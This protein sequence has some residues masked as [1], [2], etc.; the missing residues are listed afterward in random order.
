M[1]APPA[2]P[3]R[4]LWDDYTQFHRLAVATQDVDPVYPVLRHV[5]GA[6]GL[7]GLAVDAV[8]LHVAYY[9][10]G[11]ALT[12]LELRAAGTRYADLPTGLPTATERRAHRDQRQFA[13]HLRHLDDLVAL[14]GSLVRYLDAAT[15]P[16]D[17]AA[18]WTAL[19]ARVEAVHGN[20]RWAS[21]KTAEML[22]KVAGWPLAAPDMGMAG[23]SGPAHGL[24]RLGLAAPEAPPAALEDAGRLVVKSLAAAG[25]AGADLATAETTLCDFSSLAKG[26]Y[27]VG[28]DIDGMLAQ[29][30]RAA[31]GELTAAAYTARAATL[32]PAY[33]GELGGW[34]GPSRDRA[35]IYR[36]GGGIVER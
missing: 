18:R 23:A 10:L 36:D 2:A 11:S 32:P 29:L 3:A 28:M 22:Q 4:D 16:P 26:R 33:L 34:D 12:A 5:L 14:H 1:S 31:P 8:V 24:H 9:D 27:Y 21:Y 20:G 19:R 35:R 13:R 15:L 25:Q 6:A 17:P 7:A 30:R